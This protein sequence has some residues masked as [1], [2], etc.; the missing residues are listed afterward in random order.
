MIALS[1]TALS[2]ILVS[3]AL[4]SRQIADAFYNWQFNTPIRAVTHYER[5]RQFALVI[6]LT[7]RLKQLIFGISYLASDETRATVFEVY[8]IRIGARPPDAWHTDWNWSV[9]SQDHRPRDNLGFR[10]ALVHIVL[11]L[12][13]PFYVR[14][15]LKPTRDDITRLYRHRDD[16]TTLS[17]PI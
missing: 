1:I 8:R 12:N 16:R 10:W 3:R 2:A 11:C 4:Q 13:L 14:I 7:W 17:T 6:N 9:D 15:V 5:A